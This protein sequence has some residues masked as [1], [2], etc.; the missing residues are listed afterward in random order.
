MDF[1]SEVHFFLRLYLSPETSHSFFA[2]VFASLRRL[3]PSLS[4]MWLTCVLTVGSLMSSTLP[5]SAL[6]LSAQSRCSTCSSVEVSASAGDSRGYR[7]A[8]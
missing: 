5:I 7:N 2:V 1:Q 4:R 8:G 6:L 3:T